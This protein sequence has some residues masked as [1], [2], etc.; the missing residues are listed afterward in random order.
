MDNNVLSA[1]DILKEYGGVDRN[2]LKNLLDAYEHDTNEL[3]IIQNSLYYSINSLPKTIRTDAGNFTILC[4][5][6]DSLLSKIEELRIL[7]AVFGYQGIYIDVICI[8]ESHLDDTYDSNSALIQI[9]GYD[10]IP[11]GKHCGNKGG[12]VTYVRDKHESEKMELITEKSK[13]WE[14]LFVEVKTSDGFRMIVS[15]I[16]KPPRK[17]TDI[18]QFNKEIRPV[19]EKIKKE[20]CD[21]VFAGDFNINLLELNDKL[22]FQEF[23]DQMTSYSFYP[24]ITLPTRIGKRSSTLIDNIYCKMTQNTTMSNSGIVYS[25][26]SD[27]FPYFLSFKPTTTKKKNIPSAPKFIKKKTSSPEAID[28]LKEAL[29]AHDFSKDMPSLLGENDIDPNKNYNIFIEKVLHYK[30]L[31]LPEKLVKFNKHRH[32]QEKWITEGIIKSIK[33]R[34]NLHLLV[35][36]ADPESPEYPTLKLNLKTFNGILKKSIR[37]AKCLYYYEIFN[38]YKNDMKNMWANINKLITKSCKGKEIKEIIVKGQKIQDKQQIVNEFNNFY[39]NVGP[40]LAAT[41]DTHNK[42][43]FTD[44]LTKTITTSFNF[45]LY[46]LEDTEKLIKSLKTKDSFGN[47]GISV[48]LLKAISPGII[49]PLTLILNQSLIS[50]I[51]PDTLKIAKVIPLYKKEDR[52]I[53]GN[54]RP[55]SLLNA[56]SKIFERAAYNQLYSYFKT[57]NLFYEHQYGF[58]EQHS[59]EHASLELIDQV[60]HDLDKKKNPVVVYMDLSKAFD[61]LDHKI[62]LHKLKYY[63]IDGIALKWFSS[64]LSNRQQYVQIDSYKSQMSEITTGVPQGSILGPLLFL[65]YMNDIPNASNIFN[66]IL[67][68]DDTSLK[69]FINSKLPGFSI[70]NSTIII[71]QE[72][73]KV[74]DWLAVNKLSLNVG[75]TK[76]MLFHMTNKKNIANIIPTLKIGDVLIERKEN[77]NF[78]GL[79]INEKLSWKP[80]VDSVSN[81]ISKYVGVLNRLKR[82][83]PSHILKTIY[84]SL[85]QS[86]MNY[87]LLAWGYNCGRLKKLQKKAIRIITNSKYLQHTTP[88]FK[89]LS[90]L[91]LEDM[92]KM[93]MLKWYYRHQ[94]KELPA[95]FTNFEIKS[96]K[97]IHDID[98]RNKNHYA[99]PVPRMQCAR[100]CLRNSI[101]TVINS[102]PQIVLEKIKTHS[103]SGFC[104]YAKKNIITNYSEICLKEDCYSCN[105]Y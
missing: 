61:T 2:M 98:T 26:I 93:N 67:F 105:S 101:S 46:E 15:N 96:Q 32:K 35:T 65:I 8:Q 99:P 55:V 18:D 74:N 27:H 89:K 104:E 94:K 68:A 84:V 13:I 83:L 64:Y 97:E 57:N 31:H 76:F 62:L 92:F 91:R 75:K 63:G 71:N 4:L 17:Y 66:F 16:Y 34:D 103:F 43:P 24:K 33:Y 79:L 38:K 19:L 87:A 60:L 88:L 58:R 54:Y 12:L 3:D 14:G 28:N 56:L 59:T 22:K 36:R 23:F 37:N 72:L 51:F 42:K 90:L 86:K 70:E 49:L 95:Y 77:F 47:D 85:I 73:Q 11:Q 53:V 6:T 50:G 20:S 39:V 45:H 21:S 100:K 9:T 102:T 41:I 82:Y 69:S 80:H 1:S 81:R 52:C 48:K 40:K 30:N 10:C 25:S 5:N 78:L 44:Y 7:I 29:L